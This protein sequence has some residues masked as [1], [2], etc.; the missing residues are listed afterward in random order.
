M[1]HFHETEATANDI[2]RIWM[3]GQDGTP[4]RLTHAPAEEAAAALRLV[5]CRLGRLYRKVVRCPVHGDSYVCWRRE[6][7]APDG[8][9]VG[10]VAEPNT[11]GEP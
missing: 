2:D 3:I 7:L 8:T 9:M 5:P 4:M 6:L 1:K 11:G 10:S